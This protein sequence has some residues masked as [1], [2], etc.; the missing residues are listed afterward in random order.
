MGN[1]QKYVERAGRKGPAL[2]DLL[3][4]REYLERWIEHEESKDVAG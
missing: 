2:P 4:A 1:I 3:K